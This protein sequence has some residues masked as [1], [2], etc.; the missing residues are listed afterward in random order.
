[1]ISSTLDTG[2]ASTW[3]GMR[4][5]D[6]MRFH[7]FKLKNSI[8]ILSSYSRFWSNTSFTGFSP[9]HTF[10]TET[11]NFA[12]ERWS[13]QHRTKIKQHTAHTYSTINPKSKLKCALSAS[14][15]PGQSAIPLN[16]TP[17]SSPSGC[18]VAVPAE[19]KHDCSHT[20]QSHSD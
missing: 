4:V 8:C 2:N 15:R 17:W 14:M 19:Q 20:G 5:E 3:S 16:W 7:V 18:W 6:E 1:M 9:F 13:N 11:S 12:I 10:S